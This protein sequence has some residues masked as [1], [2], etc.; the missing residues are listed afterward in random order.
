[1]QHGMQLNP[2][3][4]EG[5]GH[6]GSGVHGVRRIARLERIS[7]KKNPLKKLDKSN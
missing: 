6:A 2:G 5:Y 3:R 7:E 1:M 4:H